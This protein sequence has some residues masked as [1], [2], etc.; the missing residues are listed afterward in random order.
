M[1]TSV[2]ALIA[3]IFAIVWSLI[4]VLDYWQKHPDLFYSFSHFQYFDF[5]AMIG[6]IGGGL[7]LGVRKFKEVTIFQ[8]FFTGSGVLILLWLLT[9]IAHFS[10]GQKVP[11]QPLDFSAKAIANISWKF[12]STSLFLY[13]IVAVC[14]TLG[15]FFIQRLKIH[16]LD[17]DHKPTNIATGIML[18]VGI[19]FLL[20]TFSLLRP[21]IVFPLILLLGLDYKTSLQF[22]KDTLIRPFDFTKSLNAIG[23]FSFFLLLVI[24]ALNYIQVISPMPVGFDALTLYINL[25]ALIRDYAGLVAG[26][27]PYNWSLLMSLGYVLFDKTE[28]TMA[29]SYIGGILTLW[30]MFRLATQWLKL[31]TNYS[32]LALLVFYVTPTILH[33]SYRELKVDL[34]LLF[35]SLIVVI[36]FLNWMAQLRSNEE[37]VNETNLLKITALMGLLS[38]FALGIKLTTLF[39]FFGVLAGIWYAYQ[40]QKAYLSLFCFSIFGVLLV[41]LD[42]LSG[43]RAFHLGGNIIMWLM[44]VLGIGLLIWSI[45]NQ[46]ETLLKIIKTTLIYS[47]FFTLP[48]IPWLIK[49]Y[50]ETKSLAPRTLL[51]GKAVGPKISFKQVQKNWNQQKK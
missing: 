17:T 7:F 6:L 19:L 37:E 24:L 28:L 41:R 21:I 8:R 18:L 31:D 38:G 13:I 23:F 26:N 15:A 9:L 34:G 2:Y 12:F 25:P 1:K 43:M 47:L 36:L 42:D 16:L 20:G 3:G 14:N 44:L 46:K 33:Q 5:L 11:P 39:L 51:N 45:V 50:V 30:A 48:F 10:F 49:N 4:V 22:F 32:F 27:Q 29:L 35:I 40:G